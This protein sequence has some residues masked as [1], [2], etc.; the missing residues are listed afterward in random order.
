MV[1]KRKAMFFLYVTIRE[2]L[3]PINHLENLFE[4]KVISYIFIWLFKKIDPAIKQ[5]WDTY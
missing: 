3:L 4:V 5:T 2:E 1:H